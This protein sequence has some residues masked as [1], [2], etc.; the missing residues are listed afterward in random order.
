MRIGYKDNNL[1]LINWSE[2]MN[3]KSHLNTVT[4]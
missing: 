2:E 4:V 1:M 3:T